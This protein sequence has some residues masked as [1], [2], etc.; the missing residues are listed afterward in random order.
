MNV[1]PIGKPQEVFRGKVYSIIEQKVKLPSGDV[2]TY[3]FVKKPSGVIVIA[4]DDQDL[5]VLVREKR[6][7]R[8]GS[9][10]LWALP[11]GLVEDK[12]TPEKAAVKELAEE[13]GLSG[14]IEFFSRRPAAPR[15]IWDLRVFV[16]TKLKT[17]KS[18]KPELELKKV[19]LIEAVHMALDDEIENDYAALSLVEY[20]LRNNRIEI[21]E[22]EIDPRIRELMD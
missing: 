18:A 6:L 1:Q 19:P 14:Q 21:L 10:S 8:K 3:E 17:V 16:A 4:R 15:T 22:K 7:A 12:E 9:D 13:T 2:G 5:V 20:A 11:G